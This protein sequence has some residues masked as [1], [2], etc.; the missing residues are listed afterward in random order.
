[1]I[2]KNKVTINV[3][4]QSF[5][6]RFRCNG[7]IFINFKFKV[8]HS[9]LYKVNICGIYLDLF[10]YHFAYTNE[11]IFHSHVLRFDRTSSAVGVK[12][13]RELSSVW[14]YSEH[15]SIK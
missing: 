3:Y 15:F 6:K 12:I 7:N 4:T 11:M 13:D 8:P 14:L 2:G 10:P 9:Q 1:M 5:H